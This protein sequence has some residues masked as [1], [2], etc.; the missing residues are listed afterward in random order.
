MAQDVCRWSFA[1]EGRVRSLTS[2]MGFL[3]EVV[4]LVWFYDYL[5]CQRRCITLQIYNFLELSTI[6]E[7]AVTVLGFSLFWSF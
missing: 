3:V 5:A 4:P 6:N 1:I 2:S 7:Y